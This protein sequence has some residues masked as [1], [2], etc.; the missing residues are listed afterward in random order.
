MSI[1][2]LG[3]DM[4]YEKFKELVEAKGVTVHKVAVATGIPYTCL[5]D[6]KSGRSQPKA[7]K[8]KKLADY[9]GVTL[10]YFVE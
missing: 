1:L 9:F 4:L 8:L 5:A 3:G 6:W 10:N 7:D 2:L